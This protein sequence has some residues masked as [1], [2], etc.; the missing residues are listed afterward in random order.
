MAFTWIVSR[1]IRLFGQK[2]NALFYILAYRE[3]QREIAALAEKIGVP[4]DQLAKE[5]GR[6]AAAESVE[7]HANVLGYVPINPNSPEKIVKYIEVLWYVLFGQ[8]MHDYEIK[9]ED[10]TPRRQ[11][12]VFLLKYCPV[13]MG[14]EEDTGKYKELYQTFAGDK[15]EG[16]AC[17]MA[18][19]LEQLAT[20]I[21]ANKGIDIRISVRETKCYARGDGIMAVEAQ[22]MPV[23]E[24]NTATAAGLTIAAEVPQAV[25]QEQPGSKA[26][27]VNDIASQSTRLFEKISERIQLDKIDG[28]FDDPVGE[29]KLKIA[30]MIEKQLHFSPRDILAYFENYE[31]DIFRVIGYLAIH[32]LNEAGKVVENI[33]SNFFLNK[34]VDILLSGIEYGLNNYIPEKILQDNKTSTLVMMKGWASDKSCERVGTLESRDMFKL[35]L[36]GMKMALA[37]YGAE[38]LGVKDATWV[39]LKRLSVLQ[40]EQPSEAF[41]LVFDI[42][43]EAAL[44][45]GYLMAIPVKV[46]ASTEYEALKTPLE[47]ASDVY[48]S[49]R[50][51]LEKLFDLIERFQDLDIAKVGSEGSLSKTFPRMI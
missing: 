49:S 38:F 4:P 7:R 51:H 44:V 42:F 45:A 43:Q 22:V 41:S 10:T 36:E 12:L 40:E 9:V 8:E 20:I 14:H 47:M 37:D 24:F 50:E 16:Y 46:I 18:G 28:L 30:E 17:L 25:A 21:L 39:L 15:T 29:G 26:S 27:V 32:G 6:R 33:A 19:M 3:V 5:L 13:C 31:E 34:I 1:I 2:T 35:V 48:K 23:E 11:R